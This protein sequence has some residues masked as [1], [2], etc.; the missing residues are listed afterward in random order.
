MY[1]SQLNNFCSCRVLE[2]KDT[3]ATKKGEKPAPGDANEGKETEGKETEEAAEPN[4]QLNEDT[5]MSLVPGSLMI[6]EYTWQQSEGR[7]HRIEGS[8]CQGQL[9]MST[10][11]SK[12]ISLT[13]PKG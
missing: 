1:I 9:R 10:A 4:P 12:T 5:P 8:Y 2:E 3:I 7:V 11:G 6:Q 13:F